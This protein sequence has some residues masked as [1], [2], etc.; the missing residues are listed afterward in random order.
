MCVCVCVCQMSGIEALLLR[1]QFRWAGHVVRMPDNRIPKQIFYGQLA[2]GK[3]LQ[4]GPVRRYKDTLKLN[5]KQ[6]G[7]SVDSLSSAALNRTA[8]RSQCPE[9]TDDFELLKKRVWLLSNTH[10]RS[11]RV[12]FRPTILEPGHVTDVIRYASRELGFM[13]TSALTV[14]TI[15]R[16]TA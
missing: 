10:V 1:A 4:G 9:A 13:P 14:D 12:V 8:W 2:S 16:S 7:I 15:C 11:G 5:L 6:R 3:R